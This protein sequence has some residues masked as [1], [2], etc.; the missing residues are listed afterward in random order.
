MNSLY[1]RAAIRLINGDITI[2][3][4]LATEAFN[5]DMARTNGVTLGEWRRQKSGLVAS[6]RER[7]VG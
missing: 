1:I 3:S 7:M 5:R 6:I 2:A 4:A